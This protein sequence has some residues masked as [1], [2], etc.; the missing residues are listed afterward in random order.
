M[1]WS[2]TVTQYV[3][4]ARAAM[5][6]GSLPWIMYRKFAA[7]GKS[8]RGAIG[9]LPALNRA[10]AATTVGKRA[11]STF[12]ACMSAAGEM[13]SGCLRSSDIVAQAMRSASI[14]GAFPAA[15]TTCR[16][17]AANARSPAISFRRVANS[18]REGNAPRHR[19][20]AAS[21]K[22]T[23][24]ANSLSWYPPMISSPAWPST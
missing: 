7:S 22:V 11:V 13:S 4:I 14:G 24:P 3:S 19:R 21:S 16:V 23:R 2:I 9:S 6:S 1:P 5:G 18:S 12:A 20:C 15:R 10:C 8:V 17:S